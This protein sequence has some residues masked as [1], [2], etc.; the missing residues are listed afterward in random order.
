LPVTDIDVAT[1]NHV[2]KNLAAPR[3][4]RMSAIRASAPPGLL[5]ILDTPDGLAGMDFGD[6][7]AAME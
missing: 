3:R 1:I 5:V 2:Q 4:S 7:C 6:C